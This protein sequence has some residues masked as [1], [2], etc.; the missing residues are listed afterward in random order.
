MDRVWFLFD[1][2]VVDDI[3]VAINIE[4]T[5]PGSTE[6]HEYYKVSRYNSGPKYRHGSL[7]FK[8][9]EELLKSL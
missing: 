4:I 8:S 9:K 2:K 6:F 1:N 7:L 5:N 3:I